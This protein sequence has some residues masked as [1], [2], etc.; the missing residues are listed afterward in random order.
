MKASCARVCFFLLLSLF[1]ANFASARPR[2]YGN[3]QLNFQRQ[4]QPLATNNLYNQT[5]YFNL[6]DYVMVKNRFLFTAYLTRNEYVS[7]SKRVDFRPRLDFD[8]SGTPYKLFFSYLPY[9]LPSIG[10]AKVYYKQYQGLASLSPTG[11]PF[12]R[13]NWNRTDQHD[14]LTVRKSDVSFRSWSVG[15]SWNKTKFNASILFTQQENI[16]RVLREKT[17]FNRSFVTGAGVNLNVPGSGFFTSN[18]NYSRNMRDQRG[19]RTSTLNTHALTA[20][21]STPLGKKFSF[22]SNY[23]GRFSFNEQLNQNQKFQDQTLNNSVT[24]VPLSKMELSL[25][26]ADVKTLAPATQISQDYWAGIFNYFFPVWKSM[27]GKFSYSKTYFVQSTQGQYISD[28]Y[29][30][31]LGSQ[32]YQSLQIRADLSVNYRSGDLFALSRYQTSRY[33]DLRS[34]PWE[35][36]QFN[37]YYQSNLVSPK[38][39][40]NQILTESHNFYLSYFPSPGWSTTL[41]YLERYSAL[42]LV[43]KQRV[44]AGQVYHSFRGQYSLGVNYSQTKASQFLANNDL[45]SDLLSAQLT[46]FLERRTVLTLSYTASNLTKGDFTSTLGATLNQ[47]F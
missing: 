5:L 44:Y 33:F 31:S 2:I 24:F 8:L 19:V 29:Y 34:Q 41:N 23:S 28:V 30:F 3:Y 26:R 11:Y 13:F 47:Q 18:Y 12:L 39:I 40:L 9:K 42:G 1:W 35:K 6:S 20:L 21:Y 10:G 14:N 7:N 36:L 22:N 45:S 43:Q 38:L 32:I 16:D 46:L 17:L 27:D 15:S 37:Y 4:K 25:L